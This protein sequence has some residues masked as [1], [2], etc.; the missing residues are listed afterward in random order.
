MRFSE[1]MIQNLYVGYCGT[2]EGRKGGIRIR[3]L[4]FRKGRNAMSKKRKCLFLALI[5]MVV[6]ILQPLETG[7]AKYSVECLKE[8]WK[9]IKS[10]WDEEGFGVWLVE[11]GNVHSYVSGERNHQN[12]PVFF[13]MTTGIRQ[14]TYLSKK[15]MEGNH[16]VG[17][18]GVLRVYL[19][20]R[21]GKDLTNQKLPQGGLVP[22][23]PSRPM[24]AL[25]FD[26]GPSNHTL[27][28]LDTLSHYRSRATF[29]VLGSLI[30]DNQEIIR[31]AHDR[32]NE[33]LGHSWSHVNFN[34]SSRAQVI[35]EITRTYNAITDVVGEAPRLYRPPYGSANAAVIEVSEE[36]GFSII[37]WN[38]D[39]FDWRTTDEDEIYDSIM[40][41]V[42]HRS[43]IV[44]HDTRGS[45][46][47]A[48]ER[49]IP[50]LIAKG[51]QLVT[52]SEMFYYLGEELEPGT[53]ICWSW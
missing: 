39:P 3:T 43:I 49:V 35:S 40:E 12:N 44:L 33:I 5:L 38:Q 13:E 29:F 8:G 30:E 7:A 9:V 52:V 21:S 37:N 27:D 41:E 45:T 4:E 24:V 42:R 11:L 2:F 51:Y 50:S 17:E 16:G 20:G 28:I 18:T 26:D 19:L 15:S 1:R 53:V 23:D 34:R 10:D 47:R 36:L 32:G 6:M 25:T 46:A 31:L 14:L 48:M 22:I